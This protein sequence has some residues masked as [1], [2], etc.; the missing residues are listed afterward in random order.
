MVFTSFILV[1]FSQPSAYWDGPQITLEL[2]EDGSAATVAAQPHVITMATPSSTIKYPLP[3]NS[4]YN[5]NER[6]F[7]FGECSTPSGAR[8]TIFDIGTESDY[9]WVETSWLDTSG[10]LQRH[11]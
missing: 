5:N 7:I 10:S 11:R 9:D 6:V 4:K 1:Q 8:L 2:T 3:P